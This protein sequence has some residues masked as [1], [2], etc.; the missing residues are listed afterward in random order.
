MNYPLA[1]ILPS[2]FYFVSV[3]LIKLFCSF[4]NKKLNEGI[5]YNKNLII[6]ISVNLYLYC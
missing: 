1:K 4:F 6:S 5:K 2:A 3:I